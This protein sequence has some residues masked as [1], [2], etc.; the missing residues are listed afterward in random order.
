[1]QILATTRPLCR[2][3]AV[4]PV[5]SGRRVLWAGQRHCRLQGD[6]QRRVAPLPRCSLW[7]ALGQLCTCELFET[8][9]HEGKDV[10]AIYRTHG[11]LDFYDEQHR[12]IQD[13]GQQFAGERF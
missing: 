12:D 5:P 7:A 8:L 10:K 3:P 2:L 4:A 9:A 13:A 11:L 6:A 1:M